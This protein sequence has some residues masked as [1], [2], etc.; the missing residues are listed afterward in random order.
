MPPSVDRDPHRLRILNVA[1]STAVWGAELIILR[2]APLLVARGVDVVLAAPPD[3]PLEAA[4]RA[5][6]LPF[7]PIDVL[8]HRGLRDEDGSGQRPGLVALGYEATVVSRSAARLAGVIGRTGADL[9]HSHSLQAHL[10]IA[11]AARGRR[12]RAV[13]HQHDLVVPGAGRAV[14]GA[15]T[16]TAGELIAI[17]GAVA[18]CVPSW[19]RRRVDV[20]HH[21]VDLERFHPAPADPEVRRALT[22]D[23]DA[24]VVG[25][26]GRVDPRKQVDLVVRALAKLEDHAV[27]VHLAV[28]GGAHLASPEYTEN[29][30]READ[31]LLGARVRFVGPRDDVPDVLR[32]LDVLV[33]AS[34]AEPFGLTL[35]E[36]Q[37]CGIPVVA[38]RSGGAPETVVDG[39]TGFVVPAGDEVALARAIDD[40][41][42]D[43]A[44]RVRMGLAARRHAATNHDI[45]TQ[46]DRI[47]EIYRRT[48]RRTPRSTSS[49]AAR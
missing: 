26:V 36:A 21:G 49:S 27:P 12:R 46:A 11:I 15:A 2:L 33:N 23:E 19:A 20:V 6:G 34:V 28:V 25:I 40:L 9:V 37:A 4:W 7:V 10:E 35:V 5:T 24:L 29:L 32:A 45:G 42:S 44:R 41:A 48:A 18:D 47:V 17:S 30:R 43:S 14:L 38:M 13:L 16:V 31:A 8:P 22:G 3:G 1:Y 39:V